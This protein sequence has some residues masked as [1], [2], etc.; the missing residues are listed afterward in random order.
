[1]NKDT[2]NNSESC[3][4][5]VDHGYPKGLYKLPN[6]YS[7]APDKIELKR[8]VLSNYQ[9]KIADLYNNCN[10]HYNALLW[11]IPTLF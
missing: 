1:M 7:L 4:V 8:K 6:D 3:V 9:L 5:E 2:R 11:K 10:D